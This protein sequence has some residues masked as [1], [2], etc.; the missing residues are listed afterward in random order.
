MF[1][2]LGRYLLIGIEWLNNNAIHN[3]A[4]T[5]IIATFFIKLLALPFDINQRQSMAKMSSLNPQL[6]KLQKRYESNPEVLQKKTQE[7]Y[8][9]ERISPYA[10][11]LPMLVTM[12]IFMIFLRAMTFW[13]YIGSINI[14]DNARIQYEQAYDDGQV[15]VIERGGENDVLSNYKWAWTH[16]LWMPDSFLSDSIMPYSQFGAIPFDK[17][18]LYFD[19]DTLDHLA[20]VDKGAYDKIMRPYFKAYSEVRNGWGILPLLAAGSMMLIQLIQKKLNPQQAATQAQAGGMGTGMNI[21]MAIFSGYICFQYN[22]A[23]SLYW[24]ASNVAS[25]LVTVGLSFYTRKKER[26][27]ALEMGHIEA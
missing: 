22:T 13:S 9:K 24:L 8:K 11:C 17:M 15:L 10:S 18:D 21:F 7:L 12:F 23:F 27:A 16:N 4:F 25:L 19:Q 5:V 26:D 3:I 20:Q 2:F 1:E 14:Y 6:Q